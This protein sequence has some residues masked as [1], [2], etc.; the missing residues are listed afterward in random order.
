MAPPTQHSEIGEEV[1]TYTLLLDT[2]EDDVGIES[3]EWLLDSGPGSRALVFIHD[4]PDDDP[5]VRFADIVAKCEAESI[6]IVVRTS[7]EQAQ[8]EAQELLEINRLKL[9][10]PGSDAAIDAAARAGTQ[11]APTLPGTAGLLEEFVQP[12]D[13][14]AGPPSRVA[15]GGPMTPHLGD[16]VSAEL[17][18]DEDMLISEELAVRIRAWPVRT[19]IGTVF[20]ANDHKDIA[21]ALQG[22][23][24]KHLRVPVRVPDGQFGGPGKYMHVHASAA[25]PPDPSTGASMFLELYGHIAIV[26]EHDLR[27]IEG[28]LWQRQFRRDAREHHGV[29]RLPGR[30]VVRLE[31]ATWANVSY[32]GFD[33]PFYM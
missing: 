32:P 25:T 10:S 24:Q 14:P 5:L 12:Q 29:A 7:A 6:S 4:Q 8:L 20:V 26:G 11:H 17:L 19:L 2:S 21:R 22:H 9:A 18:K 33:V 30:L 28:A 3:I 16:R 13:L 27:T 15:P 31:A 23:V 1:P